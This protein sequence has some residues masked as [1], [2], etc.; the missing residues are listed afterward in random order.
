MA[1]ARCETCRFF[2]AQEHAN[3]CRRYPPAFFINKFNDGY[4]HQIRE[5]SSAYPYTSTLDWCGEHQ[6]RPEAE[7]E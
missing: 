1:D 3:Y 2:D 5:P 4:G 7:K 6:P